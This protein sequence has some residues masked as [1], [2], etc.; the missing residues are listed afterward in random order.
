[1]TDEEAKKLIA[2][3]DALP[4]IGAVREDGKAWAGSKTAKIVNGKAKAHIDTWYLI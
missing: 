4:P 2:A 3:L 1:M